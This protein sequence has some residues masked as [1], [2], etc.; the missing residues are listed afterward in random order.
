MKVRAVDF[1]AV[2]VP[3][4]RW[5]EAHDFYGGTLGLV[6]ED[7]TD[8]DEVWTEYDA[9]PLTIALVRDD[10]THVAVNRNGDG[11]S[12]VTIALAVQSVEAAL[13]ELQGK[14]VEATFGPSE[15]RP[16]YIAG[17]LDPFGNTIFIHQRKDGTAG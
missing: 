9:G 14:G 17:I 12:A 11:G 16:C 4:A 3:R 2:S 13:A 8:D 7:P 10:N 6:T 1:I 15:Y 5:Q